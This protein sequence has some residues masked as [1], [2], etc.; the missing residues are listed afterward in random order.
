MTTTV[1]T[2]PWMTTAESL[3]STKETPGSGN[4]PTILTWAKSIGGWVASYYK[5]DS[6]PWCGLFT[7]WCFKANDIKVSL[8][9]PLYSLNWL[10]FGTKTDPC[11]GAIMVFSRT[12]G[13]H[14][15]FYVSE[16][17][18][19]YHILGGNQENSV[20]VTRVSKSR[21][22]GARWPTGLEDL[23]T[24]GRIKRTFAGKLSVN[25]A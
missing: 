3:L 1:K 17:A 4:N 2:L 24:P 12:D 21:F 16:D 9:N 8:D 5:Q 7:I 14:V 19:A 15:G 18:E 22:K 23:K 25:E 13:G 10:K 11:Y 20:N 6:I